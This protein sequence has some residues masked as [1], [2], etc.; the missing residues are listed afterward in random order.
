MP[1]LGFGRPQIVNATQLPWWIARDL[2]KPK[3]K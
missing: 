3:E 1:P 2:A